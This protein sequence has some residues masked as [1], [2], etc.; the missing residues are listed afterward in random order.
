MKLGGWPLKFGISI[1]FD[2]TLNTA[3]AKSIAAETSKLDYLWIPDLP[4]Q[5][6]PP[7]IAAAAASRTSRI[8]IGLGL[9]S[10]I[11]HRPIQIASS[12][13]TLIEYYGERFELCIGPGDRDNLRMVGIDLERIS[14]IPK[15]ILE[16]KNEISEHL[17]RVGLRCRVWL[18]AQ[19]PRMLKI[20][21][22]FDGAL[23]NYSDPEMVAWALNK[24][25]RPYETR[26]WAAGI[27]APAYIYREFKPE[28]YRVL[29]FA[30]ATV[31][32]GTSEHV[33]KRFGLK[34]IV[35]SIRGQ[36]GSKPFSTSVLRMVPPTV[37]ER[38][39]IL[40]SQEE[41]PSYIRTLESLG[42]EQVVFAYPQAI[43]LET[44]RELGEILEATSKE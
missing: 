1:N 33:L 2:D 41:L 10:P 23:L 15:M 26:K 18:G 40:K 8:R 32:L 3:V 6:Y 31:A 43:S 35:T 17:D 39:Y 44:I 22:K 34:D 20:A 21:S 27:F 36:Y 11:L 16:A 30:S 12:M 28:I 25:G 14:G 24:I 19:G 29:R 7:A 42:I 38:F 4:N 9:I 5:R 37:T 13:R